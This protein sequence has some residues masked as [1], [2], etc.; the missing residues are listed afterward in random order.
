MSG[1][2]RAI[3][4]AQFRTIRNYLPRTS[5]G[6]VLLALLSLLWYG[7]FIGLGGLLAAFCRRRPSQRIEG[8]PAGGTA[9]PA[10]FLA[11]VSG[12]DD[13]QWLVA[14]VEQAAGL[15]DPHATRCFAV[16]VLLRLT[17]AP[18][19]VFVLLG[20]V[21]GLQRHPAIHGAMAASATAVSALQSF[22]V[23][24][25][26]RMDAQAVQKEALA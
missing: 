19:A 16:E 22:S 9:G 4:W 17:T 14:G 26:P 7:L 3:V 8:I 18:E 1:Q 2:I 11:G 12:D 24:G 5:W 20:V 25:D 13:E 10:H 21:I 23:A 15:P 6:A